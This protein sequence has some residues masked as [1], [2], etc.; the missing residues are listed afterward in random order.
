MANTLGELVQEAGVFAAAHRHNRVAQ[1]Q[2]AYD[3]TFE[4]REYFRIAMDNRPRVQLQGIEEL[5]MELADELP[6][7][8]WELRELIH[9]ARPLWDDEEDMARELAV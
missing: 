6:I 7:L 2:W 8:P 4:E 5:T 3:R 1:R 9:V